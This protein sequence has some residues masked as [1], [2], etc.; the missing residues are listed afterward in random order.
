[1][2]PSKTS[3]HRGARLVPGSHGEVTSRAGRG[4]RSWTQVGGASEEGPRGSAV[5]HSPSHRLTV[6]TWEAA[7]TALH[8][9]P[10][11]RTGRF[12]RPSSLRNNSSGR[13]Q[14][15]MKGKE[16]ASHRAGLQMRAGP[17]GTV[18]ESRRQDRGGLGVQQLTARHGH[19]G[20]GLLSGVRGMH[21][22]WDPPSD[23]TGS[24]RK[25]GPKSSAAQAHS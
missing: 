4:Q 8:E 12:I 17:Q 20:P 10:G 3:D 9:H 7:R 11:D 5:S 18:T 14:R 19:C 23:S 15:V 2:P 6:G 25:C 16:P 1:M 24:P 21:S 13:D 22:S